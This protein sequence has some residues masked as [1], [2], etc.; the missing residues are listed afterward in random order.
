MNKY[1]I[2]SLFLVLSL[3]SGNATTSTKREVRAVWLTT[4]GGLDW[5]HNYASGMDGVERQKKELCSLLD[6]YRDAGINTVLLQ[7]RIRGTVIYPSLIEP[8]DGCL[9]GTPG[10][11]PGYDALSFAI[12]EC[13]ERGME[14]HAWVVTIPVGKWKAYGCSSLHKKQP[15]LIRKIGDEGY[16]D[17]ENK[18]TADY[19]ERIC[20]E[21]TENYDIDGIH[22]DYIRYPETWKLKISRQEGRDNITNIV[23]QIST[24]VKSIKPWVKMS[25]SPVGKHDD[26]S[27]YSSKGWNAYTKVCQDAKGWLKEGLMDQIY[28]MMYFRGDNFYPF[29]LDWAE[30][31]NGRM[32]VPGLGIYFLSP[33]EG[34]WN[35]DDVTREMYVCRDYSMGH[36]YFRGKFLTDNTQGI[37]DFA[38]WFDRHPALVPAMTWEKDT[39]PDA[40]TGLCNDGQTLSW[41]PADD[42]DVTYN[43]YAGTACPVD[44]DDPRNLV[45]TRLNRCHATIDGRRRH[46]AI[47]AMDRY[48]NESKPL[49]ETMPE[50]TEPIVSGLL[51]CNGTLLEMPHA[52]QGCETDL[53]AI[54]SIYGNIVTTKKYAKYVNISELPCGLYTARTLNSRG[55]SHRIGIFMVV[56]LNKHLK[57]R[58]SSTFWKL[59]SYRE[60]SLPLVAGS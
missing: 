36:A 31:S 50:G 1:T 30:G 42:T 43:I 5:P 35:I 2:F 20:Q 16:M 46:Y 27:L 29:A 53:I 7:T 38:S 60:L 13:H 25:C 49:Q 56:R 15:K 52:E 45:V 51:T 12:D 14:L 6:R 37:Y 9:S 57:F 3:L 54:T 21:I 44:T 24:R 18:A 11:S 19:L 41:T 33:K 8:W 55:M 59:R 40:P 47:T 23:R 39:P 34:N 10:K 17:P 26:L 48:G 28:P 32:V 4:I 58:M 22:L